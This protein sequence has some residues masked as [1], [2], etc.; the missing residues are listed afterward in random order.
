MKSCRRLVYP[1]LLLEE[2]IDIE[3]ERVDAIVFHDTH[4]R[5]HHV[6]LMAIRV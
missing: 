1:Q 2:F 3:D 4:E 5:V 6:L